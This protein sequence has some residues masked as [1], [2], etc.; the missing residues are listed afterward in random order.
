VLE[1][2]SRD[3]EKGYPARK[4]MLW[5]RQGK[6]PRTLTAEPGVHAYCELVPAQV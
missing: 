3:R 2:L 6:A 4:L 5:Q 1:V